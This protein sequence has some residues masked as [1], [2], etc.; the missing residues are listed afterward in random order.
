MNYMDKCYSKAVEANES[1][2][3]KIRSL[4]DYISENNI[5]TEKQRKEISENICKIVSLCRTQCKALD[6]IIMNERIRERE[7]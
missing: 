3:Q 4:F 1:I 2:L 5:G 7:Q 6:D